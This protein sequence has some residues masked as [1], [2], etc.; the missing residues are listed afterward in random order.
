[1]P[2]FPASPKPVSTLIATLGSEAQVVT[3]TLDH[4][5]ESG[6]RVERVVVVHTAAPAG[7]VA[8]AMPRVRAEFESGYYAP[9]IELQTLQL[10]S[11]AG[12]LTDVDTADGSA[13]AFKA[14]YQAV[15]AE[16]LAERRVHLSIAGGRKTMSVFGLAAAQ[17]LFDQSDRL[18]HLVS[19]GRLLD[20]K[21]MHAQPG[22]DLSLVEIPVI[23]WSA[24]SPVLTDLREV[25]DPFVAVERQR[26]LK[27]QEAIDEARAFVLGALSPAEKLAIDLLVREGLTD[28]QIAERLNLSKRTIEKQTGEARAKAAVHWGLESVSRT[29]LV[30]LL[31]VYYAVTD[32][33]G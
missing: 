3:L 10:N 24:V 8:E 32:D 31:S 25:D 15:R 16:K 18:W 5:R 23:L 4:L 26:N 7:P 13:V 6:E 11:A 28:P 33:N 2:S 14:I 22:D 1:L 21:R 12:P 29:L 19:Y 30:K 20:E 17:M 9:A 27:V